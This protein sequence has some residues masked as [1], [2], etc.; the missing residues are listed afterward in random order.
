MV[1][2]EGRFARNAFPYSDLNAFTGADNAARNACQVTVTKAI[3]TANIPATAKMSQP[4]FVLYS[5]SFS[6]EFIRYQ[7]NGAATANETITSLMKLP[8]S[9]RKIVRTDAPRTSL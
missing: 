3:R 4:S 9:N 5:K 7:P 1:C 2:G 6:H 8:V